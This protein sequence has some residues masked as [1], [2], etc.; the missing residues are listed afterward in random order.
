MAVA[1]LRRMGWE[2]RIS[3][4][5]SSEICLS[6]VAQ[7]A[8]GLEARN[9]DGVAG[10]IAFLHHLPTAMEVTAERALLRRLGGGCQIPVGA[11]AWFEGG[12]IRLLGVVADVDG[13]KL[14]RAEISGDSEKAERLG[15]ELAERLLSQGADEIL[16]SSRPPHEEKA[17]GHGS[18]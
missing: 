2:N 7:G 17:V 12:Q 13:R 6:A 4:Y 3:E 14:F 16:A 18:Q 1:G 8:L 10:R 5:L 11:R 9:G 15:K